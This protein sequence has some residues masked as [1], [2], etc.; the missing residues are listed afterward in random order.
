MRRCFGFELDGRTLVA[1]EAAIIQAVAGRILAGE[2]VRAVVRDLRADD[3]RT[4]AHHLWTAQSL[5]RLLRNP[6][7]AG[8]TAG[9]GN[10]PAVLPSAVHSALVQRLAAPSSAVRPATNVRRH[11]LSGLLTCGR[12]ADEAGSRC[13]TIL[14][15]EPDG[16]RRP[17]YVCRS[18][19]PAYGCGRTRIAAAV[20]EDAVREQALTRLRTP[21]VTARLT[22]L[23]GAAVDQPELIGKAIA[24]LRE[25]RAEVR[26][27]EA[28]QHLRPDT[29]AALVE[30]IRRDRRHL[31]EQLAQAARLRTL[32]GIVAL[33]QWWAQA[34]P[35]QVRDLTALVLER[36]VVNPAGRSGARAL[37]LTRLEFVWK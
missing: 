4:S 34:T 16:V 1:S 5:V 12:A 22:A 24:A 2:S 6:R 35:D 32:N 11:R 23:A 21:R 37:D 9:D 14:N 13:G 19:S 28:D 20:L 8:R 27:M 26:R 31:Q 30:E 29:A 36:V 18:G 10:G 25:R 33:D 17:G 3:A 7:I 15:R